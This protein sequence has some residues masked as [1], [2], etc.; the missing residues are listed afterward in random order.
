MV[1]LSARYELDSDEELID[2]DFDGQMVR[3]L[4]YPTHPIDPNTVAPP[5]P[6]EQPGQGRDPRA[7]KPDKTT[8]PSCRQ[9]RAKDD[10]E[11]A[12]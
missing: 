4:A 3:Q 9:S 6:G 10:W 2:Q 1:E 8:C 11:L 5:A 7:A 12:R